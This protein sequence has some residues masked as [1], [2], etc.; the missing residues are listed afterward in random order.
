MGNP[1]EETNTMVEE[2]VEEQ[3]REEEAEESS[4]PEEEPTVT[5][6]VPTPSAP[7]EGDEKPTFDY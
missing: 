5:E 1:D 7:D 2:T 6:E 4:Q 3:N